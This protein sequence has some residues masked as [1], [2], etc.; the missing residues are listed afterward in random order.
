MP[1]S[2]TSISSRLI[3]ILSFALALWALSATPAG[4]AA[5]ATSGTME[6][7]EALSSLQDQCLNRAERS[8]NPDKMKA[9][10]IGWAVLALE[11]KDMRPAKAAALRDAC[12]REARYGAETRIREATERSVALCQALYATVAE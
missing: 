10:C 7:P 12:I 8:D 5:I 6:A 4:A 9:I 1:R 2:A 3:W 11:S